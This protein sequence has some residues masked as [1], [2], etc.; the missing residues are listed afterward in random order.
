MSSA[1]VTFQEK[2][3]TLSAHRQP[4]MEVFDLLLSCPSSLSQMC[5]PKE[6]CCCGGSEAPHCGFRLGRPG[7]DV[8]ISAGEEDFFREGAKVTAYHCEPKPEAKKEE[9]VEVVALVGVW[10]VQFGG[11]VARREVSTAGRVNGSGNIISRSL[12]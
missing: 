9:E 11:G 7:S 1:D 12:R 5:R 3:A 10:E 4:T 8:Q 2:L 6:A